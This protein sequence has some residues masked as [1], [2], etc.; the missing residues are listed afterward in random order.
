MDRKALGL[1]LRGRARAGQ[2]DACVDAQVSLQASGGEDSAG[3]AAGG[4]GG[5]LG[6]RRVLGGR[7]GKQECAGQASQAQPSHPHR[8]ASIERAGSGSSVAGKP[9][10][11]PGVARKAKSV[12][13]FG[14]A[15]DPC[16]GCGAPPTSLVDRSLSSGDTVC[17]CCGL[18][19]HAR[20]A[21]AGQEWRVFED[22][23]R[24]GAASLARAGTGAAADSMMG[25]I[26]IGGT[27]GHA[28][29]LIE[30]ALRSTSP[31]STN[32]GAGAG[33]PHAGSILMD[34]DTEHAAAE[35]ARA[36]AKRSRAQMESSRA[37]AATRDSWKS[38]GL[39]HGQSAA[40]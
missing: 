31:A 18:V 20:A 3:S 30:L 23:D 9:K 13:L 24:A 10:R 11:I 34:L 2:V 1:A 4:T 26:R 5:A 36:G 17:A 40:V 37:E 21:F 12:H 39:L 15:L 38:N 33:L 28:G 7:G 6:E 35:F 14:L 16:R 19:Q 27:K 29:P 25:G 32:A 8:D 22:D